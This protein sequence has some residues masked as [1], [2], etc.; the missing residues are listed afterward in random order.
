VYG[1][2]VTG[3]AG[4]QRRA[5]ALHELVREL[6]HGRHV[7]TLALPAAAGTRSAQEVLAWQ[8]GYADSVELASGHPEWIA[9]S[10]SLFTDERVDV[11]L[12]L[13]AE[14]HDIPE[15]VA[16]I[17]LGSLL[18]QDADVWVR[19]APAGVAAP[20]TAHR[21]DGVP[22]ALQAPVPGDAPTAATL[23]NRLLEAVGR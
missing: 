12:C 7:V 8:T 3:G 18:L 4:G 1:A 21:L 6:S 16:R 20:G 15:G 23:L 2:G 9:G 13:G 19:T 22:L 10:E 17:G 14:R 5:L 11:S